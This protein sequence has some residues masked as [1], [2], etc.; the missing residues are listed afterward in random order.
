MGGDFSQL[1]LRE[2]CPAL[3]LIP[4]PDQCTP[5]PEHAK[6]TPFQM[7]CETG[8][9]L[10][11]PTLLGFLSVPGLSRDA[12]PTT[13]YLYTPPITVENLPADINL[14]QLA[15][16]TLSYLADGLPGMGPVAFPPRCVEDPQRK[17]HIGAL[18]KALEM[19]LS[20]ERGRR[21]CDGVSGDDK[22]LSDAQSARKWGLE[23]KTLRQDMEKKTPVSHLAP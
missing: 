1:V 16:L 22:S 23:L 6:C 17:R 2:A 18:G 7:A 13:K 14:P 10:R 19:Y 9:I 3:P 4:E 5:C 12:T 15:Y 11:P 20:R 8:Y 21:L